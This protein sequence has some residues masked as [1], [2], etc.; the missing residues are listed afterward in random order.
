M[1]R[2]T[3]QGR[4]LIAFLFSVIT[5]NSNLNAQWSTASTAPD[6]SA[7]QILNLQKDQAG[8]RKFVIVDVRT[9][10]ESNVSIIPGAITVA[11]FEKNVRQYQGRTVITYCTVGVRS[12]NYANKLKQQGWEAFNYRGSILD[13]CKNKL[14][15]TTRTGET[16]RRVHIYSRWYSVPSEYAAIY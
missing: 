15:L 11:E 13:W 2:K 8:K 6:I 16:T 7:N 9:A 14:P 1:D 10:A 5:C 3:A 12:G 4:V